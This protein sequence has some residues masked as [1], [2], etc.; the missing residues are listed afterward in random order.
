MSDHIFCVRGIGNLINTFAIEGTFYVWNFTLNM[1]NKGFL[2]FL[3]EK[4]EL[5]AEKNLFT[6][7]E[8]EDRSTAFPVAEVTKR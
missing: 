3:V 8:R 6:K 1:L 2:T 5:F 7:R 4:K